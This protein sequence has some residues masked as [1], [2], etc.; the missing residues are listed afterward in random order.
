[1]D[2]DA[3][4]LLIEEQLR[5]CT[6]EQRDFFSQV[7]VSLQE[8]PIMRYGKGESVFVVARHNNE[9]MYYEEAEEGFNI[10]PVG[11]AG[12]IL[13]HW[14]NQDELRH[15][16]TAWMGG[17]KQKLGPGVPVGTKS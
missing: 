15:A 3:L 10:S 7:R 17:R 6:D 16:L 9:A 14:C 1:M 4:E 12:E 13:Q 11:S 8:A 5:D 2:R